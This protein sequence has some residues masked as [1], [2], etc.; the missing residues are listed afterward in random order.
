MEDHGEYL[1]IVLKMADYDETWKKVDMEQ[2]SL[3]LMPGCVI[4]FQ[5][6]PGDV[7][8]PVRDRL[9]TAKG[10]IRS[11]G[12]DYLAYALLDAVVDR[13]FLLLEKLGE[14]VEELDEQILTDPGEEAVSNLHTLKREMIFLRK[15]AWPMR[16]IVASLERGGSDLVTPDTAFFLRDL[17]DHSVQVMDSI[18]TFRDVLSGLL[19]IYLSSTGNRMNEIMK[20]LT[21]I[22]TIFIPLTFIAGIY[23]MNFEYM[24]ELEV[25]W[26][27]PAVWV[28][29]ITIAGGMLAFFRK[30]KWI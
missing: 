12:A 22:S 29:M 2:V 10:K 16:E 18:E 3:I 14:D 28:V 15:A 25:P 20:V 24:P 7:F 30:K 8:D 27:Y 4:T 17:Y 19:D 11:K 23:G 5:E 21:I 6:K 13:Y 9:R 26:A 1:Y